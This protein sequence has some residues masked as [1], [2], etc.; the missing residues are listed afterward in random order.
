MLVS[1]TIRLL[2]KGLEAPERTHLVVNNAVATPQSDI[3][4]LNLANDPMPALQP[5][6]EDTISEIC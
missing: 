5:S 1:Q 2:E 4:T 3:L 6:Y